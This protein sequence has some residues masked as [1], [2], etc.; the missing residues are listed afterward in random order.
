MQRRKGEVCITTRRR[1]CT[2]LTAGLFDTG[3]VEGS[4]AVVD[5]C[6]GESEVCIAA[7][8]CRA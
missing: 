2:P 1:R 3:G 6:G 5:V 8:V 7:P 4:A